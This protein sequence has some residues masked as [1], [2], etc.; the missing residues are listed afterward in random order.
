MKGRF[1]QNVPPTCSR[2]CLT[3]YFQTYVG[4][5]R[6]YFGDP[7][8][9]PPQD[10]CRPAYV[11]FDS[12]ENAAEAFKRVGGFYIPIRDTLCLSLGPLKAS[13]EGTTEEKTEEKEKAAPSFVPKCSVWKAFQKPS[14]IHARANAEDRLKVDYEQCVA[15][16][17]ALST[18]WVIVK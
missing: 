6:I 15:L 13:V 11:L 16:W 7:F 17:N 18:Y 10:L 2:Q 3:E 8:H 5:Q 1:I 4:F 14:V 9:C 12:N